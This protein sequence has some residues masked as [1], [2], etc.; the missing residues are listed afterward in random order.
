[1][2]HALAGFS[3]GLSVVAAEVDGQLVGMAANSLVSVSLDSPLV[4]LSFARVDD[5]AH[6]PAG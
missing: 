2:R 5:L 3:T 6:S 4:S 1:M